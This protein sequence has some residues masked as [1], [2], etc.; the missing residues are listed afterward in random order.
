M[1]QNADNI[2]L[3]S[4]AV[5][6]ILGRPPKWII[7]WGIT[8]ILIIIAGIFIGSY[9]VKYPEVIASTIEV[10]TENLPAHLVARSSGKI[11]SLFVKENE[12]VQDGG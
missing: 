10:S 1:I 3:R 8:V 9:F 6:E 2:E 5:Q 4:E 11:D 12:S 7:R